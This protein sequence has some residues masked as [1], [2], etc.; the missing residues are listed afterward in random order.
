[1]KHILLLLLLLLASALPATAESPLHIFHTAPAP[2][3]AFRSSC[4]QQLALRL[5]ADYGLP[6]ESVG[7]A[8]IEGIPLTLEKNHRGEV[9][10]IGFS[11]FTPQMQA[12]NPSPA[13]HFVERYL[14]QLFVE[15]DKWLVGQMLKEDKVKLWARGVA[16]TDC[17]ATLAR[18]LPQVAKADNLS[19]TTDNSH[20]SVQWM[21]GD[22]PL[23]GMRFP[24]QYEL[25]WGMSKKEAEA[26]LYQDLLHAA[27]SPQTNHDELLQLP[28]RED[29]LPSV[30][31]NCYVQAGEWYAVEQMNTNR[32]FSRTADGAWQPLCSIRRAEESVQNFFTRQAD[33]RL[34]ANVT[35][36]LYGQKRLQFG[37]GLQQLIDFCRSEGCEVFFGIEKRE[38]N[39]IHATAML[40]NRP[41]GYNHLLYIKIDVRAIQQPARYLADIELYA[42]VPTHNLHSLYTKGK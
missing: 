13:Y 11:L 18:I 9:I 33:A 12:F 1:M 34:Q 4:L 8:R 21:E 22:R 10:H 24:I 40:L 26:K 19:I 41:L 32:Y 17:H 29:T 28:A 7:G 2:A 27:N 35:Q 31:G 36:R 25:L 30:A 37:I 39:R 6:A 23:F 20:F 38:G 14:L 15:K 5:E 42:Y 16:V 3:P